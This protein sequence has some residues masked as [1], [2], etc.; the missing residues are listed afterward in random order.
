MS[1]KQKEFQQRQL[2]HE[3]GVQSA[4]FWSIKM[5]KRLSTIFLLAIIGVGVYFV[6]ERSHHSAE[7]KGHELAKDLVRGL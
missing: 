4:K 6:M 5:K 1:L 2:A 7:N 3:Y